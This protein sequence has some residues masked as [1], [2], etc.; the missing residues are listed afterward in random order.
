MLHVFSTSK[1]VGVKELKSYCAA[2]GL[3]TTGKKEVLKNRLVAFSET[4]ERWETY[5]VIASLRLTSPSHLI[6]LN[7]SH[8][9]SN[10]GLLAP[11]LVRAVSPSVERAQ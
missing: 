8:T 11:N 6:H 9:D 1:K 5:V 2:F 4:P 10:H 7:S 3:P